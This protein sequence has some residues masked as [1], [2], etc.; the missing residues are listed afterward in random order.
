MEIKLKDFRVL[1]PVFFFLCIFYW[2]PFIS[3]EA[4][5]LLKLIILGCLFF[6]VVIFINR[7][8]VKK[9]FLKSTILFFAIVYELLAQGSGNFLL[10]IMVF[11]LMYDLGVNTKINKINYIFLLLSAFTFFWVFLSYFI[12]SINY[13][14]LLFLDYSYRDITLA[15]TGFSIARTSWGLSVVLLTLFL[16]QYSNNKISKIIL[17]LSAFLCIITTGSR[18]A[19]ICLFVIL[20][21]I[22]IFKI[23]SKVLR[24]VFL[25]A[26]FFI[27]LILYITMGQFLRLAGSEDFS[28]GRLELY[29]LLNQIYN[30]N[31]FLGWYPYGG[32]NL[33]NYGYSFTQF[34][35]A[36]IHFIL[37][38]GFLGW[39]IFL[40]W[41]IYCLL[42]LNLEN[43]KEKIF[44]FL[45]LICGFISTFLEPETVFS[46]GYHVLIFWYTLGLLSKSNIQNQG[47][48]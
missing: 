9:I 24:L 29:K 10:I 25:I 19:L 12:S 39:G 8:N 32:Y 45:I 14:N 17:F 28:N 36:W 18:T 44:L 33:E 37:E 20:V 38:Y 4:L 31:I 15:S 13:N 5:S 48:L 21:F 47:D 3:N 2:F 30:E 41:L 35:N 27:F 22:S 46:Y 16:L 7:V 11:V 6:S 40:T 1:I 43:F 26:S 34:H 23:N 42:N